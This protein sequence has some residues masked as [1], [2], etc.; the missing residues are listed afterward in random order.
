MATAVAAETP[1]AC[2][3]ASRIYP[4]KSAGPDNIPGRVLRECPEQ[5]ADVFTEI[6]NISLNSTVVLTCLKT[7]IVTMLKKSTGSWTSCTTTLS[8]WAPQGC[9][10]SPLLFILLTHD[11]VTMHS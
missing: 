8:T 4:C 1:S 11:C 10:L 3:R 2:G 6:F 5:L 7:T 9:V